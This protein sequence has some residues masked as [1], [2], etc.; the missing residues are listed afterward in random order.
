MINGK[1][2]AANQVTFSGITDTV[3][4]YP[5]LP[6]M[7]LLT[8]EVASTNNE[9]TIAFDTKYAYQYLVTGW[10]RLSTEDAGS[11]GAATW[12]GSD[13]QFFW[14]CNWLGT[15]GSDLIFFV[16]NF[17]PNEANGMR[18]LLSG[19]WN[20]FTIQ[21]DSTPNYV[22]AA[23]ILV[24]FKNRMV[25]LNTYEGAALPGVAYPWRARYSAVGSPLAADSWRQDIPGNGNAIDAPT[26]EAI[27]SAQFIK[28]RLIVFFERS[29]W[30]LVYTGNQI[31]PFQWQK[32]N[33]ELGVESSFSTVPFDKVAIGVGNVGIIAC[34]GANAE[35]IDDRIPDEIFLIHN[36]N[37]GTER[38]YGIRDYF[39]E[40]IY[41][42][43]PD[44]SASSTF[45]Y[46]NQVLVF[47]YKTG[48]W[49][50]FDDSITCFGYSQ[51]TDAVT[52]DSTTVT[53]DDAIPWESP[54]AQFQE[55]IAGNQEG[56]TFIC[57]P[58]A[59][60]NSMNLQITDLST[61]GDNNITIT[62]INHTIPYPGYIYIENVEGTD[63]L[64]LL[65]N[66][67]YP[68]SGYPTNANTFTIN[69]PGPETIAGTYAGGGTIGLVSNPSILTKQYNFYA[70]EGRNF[71]VNKVDFL[72][73]RTDDGE[74]T[75]S[76][77][78]STNPNLQDNVD[79]VPVIET[80]AYPDYY[81]YEENAAQVWRTVYYDAQGEYIQILIE[82]S[83]EQITTVTFDDDTDTYIIP[84]FEPFTL[85]AIIIH[86][87]PTGRL[88]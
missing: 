53:W 26:T 55:I 60:F 35:R 50:L 63:N 29:T 10:E 72:M 33:T 22:F 75:A 31:Y 17:N 37:S 30:E 6:V 49:A 62:A 74:T 18:Y 36:E 9:T 47:N 70:K 44:S 66:K 43:F 5:A 88:Q 56:F 16:T 58:G 54:P 87:S 80:F 15:N 84:A 48:T 61:S 24:I 77:A 21:V 19:S 46:P 65:N 2:T 20:N 27:I 23:R 4:F 7:G 57:D 39:T 40:L 11:P 25:A 83:L 8:Q 13:A 51:I 64:D 78:T 41:W 34:S 85:N 32:I 71:T 82:M 38:V 12:S 14:P 68:I 86:A 73:D 79:N 81:P 3:Y 28:D 45:P 42:T 67:I 69:Y 52:W 1:L 76:F 59:S